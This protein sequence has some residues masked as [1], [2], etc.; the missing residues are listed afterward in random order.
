[1]IGSIKAEWRKFVR[2]PALWW[3]AAFIVAIVAVVYAFSWI[4]ANTSGA[5]TN[6]GVAQLKAGLY[7][8]NF[9]GQVLAAESLVGSA[10]MLVLGALIVGSEY[11]W[12]SFKTVYS[13]G[14]GRWEVLGGQITA[15]SAL[16]VLVVIG[17]FVVGAVSSLV[18]ATVAGA[19]VTWPSAVV[20]LKA[21]G[22]TWLV[23]E[24]WMLF[25]MFVAYALRQ[26]AL[27]IGLGLAYMLAV[28]N[29]AFRTLAGLHLNWISEL[30]KYMVGQNTSALSSSLSSGSLGSIPSSIGLG[31]ALVVIVAYMVAFVV[32]SALIVRQRE[33][34]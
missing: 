29:I 8:N 23:F 10:L 15:M 31:H 1:M 18:L 11:G 22:A 9:P 26:S 25:G 3:L 19:A 14:P 21:A 17:V 4:A 27:A 7:P 34:A 24:V 12:G 6:P 20:V 28:E 30:E 32:V 16:N 2:R 33:I 13:Q 5:A